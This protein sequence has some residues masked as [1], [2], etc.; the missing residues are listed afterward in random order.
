MLYG[1]PGS[2]YTTD[3]YCWNTETMTDSIKAAAANHDTEVSGRAGPVR[4]LASIC[5]FSSSAMRLTVSA[6]SSGW[7]SGRRRCYRV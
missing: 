5:T 2:I 3:R 6:C 4:D 7:P 1:I